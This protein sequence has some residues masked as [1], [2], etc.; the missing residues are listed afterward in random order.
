VYNHFNHALFGSELPNAHF[1]YQ[2]KP[3]MRGHYAADR[4]TDRADHS[5]KTDEIALNP[6]EFVNKSDKD[7]C[8]TVL[9]EMCHVWRKRVCPVPHPKRTGYHD[10]AWAEKMKEVGLYPSNTG[11]VGG[12]ETGQQMSHYIIEGG[13]FDVSYDQ[14]VERT[15]WKLNLQSAQRPGARGRRNDG[16]NKYVCPHPECDQNF[17]GKPGL[18]LICG[19][20]DMR[21][22][23]PRTRAE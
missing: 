2:R 17:R 20:H 11:T 5:S 15:H 6:D 23:H 12:K 13:A 22:V 7:I 18:N 10:I 14:F 4:Y 9:H 21:C 16:H 19:L 8:G 1:V 3:H